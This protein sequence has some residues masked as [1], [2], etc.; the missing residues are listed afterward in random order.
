MESSA[1]ISPTIKDLYPDPVAKGT[2]AMDVLARVAVQA[3]TQEEEWDNREAKFGFTESQYPHE[4]ARPEDFFEAGSV[5]YVLAA[6]FLSKSW[7]KDKYCFSNWKKDIS[8]VFCDWEF[9]IGHCDEDPVVASAYNQRQEALAIIGQIRR[10][11][12]LRAEKQNSWDEFYHEIKDVI[13]KILRNNHQSSWGEDKIETFAEIVLFEF[14][15]SYLFG[16]LVI[17]ELE[18]ICKREYK[19]Y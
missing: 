4:H 7:S 5:N 9:F 8:K 3:K 18:M 14:N 13:V 16:L 2:A 17:R 19:L 1:I 12:E 6:A 10:E 11:F 15:K